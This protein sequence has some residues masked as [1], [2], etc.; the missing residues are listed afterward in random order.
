MQQELSDARDE[1]WRCRHTRK[2][3]CAFQLQRLNIETSSRQRGQARSVAAAALSAEVTRLGSLVKRLQDENIAK[4]DSKKQL[5]AE[6]EQLRRTI[7]VHSR[8]VEVAHAGKQTAETHNSFLDTELQRWKTKCDDLQISQS[9]A[10]TRCRTAN[11]LLKD[12]R[13]VAAEMEQA[14]EEARQDALE[15][16]AII[17]DLRLQAEKA[18]K[19]W[20]L[21]V[22]QHEETVQSLR[23][24]E[25]GARMARDTAQECARVAEREVAALAEALRVQTKTGLDRES[26]SMIDKETMAKAVL[27]AETALRQKADAEL[28][29]I[30][31]KNKLNMKAVEDMWSQR[32]SDAQKAEKEVVA[33][34]V[35]EAD[36]ALKQKADAELQCRVEKNKLNMK[37]VEDMWSQRLSDALMHAKEMQAKVVDETATKLAGDTQALEQ[38]LHNLSKQMVEK[39]GEVDLV[40]SDLHSVQTDLRAAKQEIQRA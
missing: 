38:D 7:A 2:K 37:A 16:E 35:L 25:S 24:S 23:D 31:E 40:R 6:I 14:A 20:N 39:Q 29:C 26:S 30:V 18:Q 34:A 15:K 10:D 9:E 1:I 5:E 36:T 19:A 8:A 32:L 4:N 27:E 13:K 33:K 11:E 17:F 3:K 12:A 21:K 28:Q 22:K